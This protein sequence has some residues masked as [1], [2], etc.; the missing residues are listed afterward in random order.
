[1]PPSLQVIQAELAVNYYNDIGYHIEDTSLQKWVDQ[2]M[3]LINA[4]FT[5]EE[6]KPENEDYLFI[7]GSHSYYWRTLLMENL[8]KWIS[9]NTE[10]IIFVFAGKKA[11]YYSDFINPEKH[12]VFNVYHPV[13]DFR[14]GRELFVGSNIFSKINNKL[15]EYGKE[16]IEF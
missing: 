7:E 10:N 3:L 16:T 9:D 11:Q 12:T 5:C 1:L 6:Y 8:F 14:S 15:T 2:G 13:A 4:S